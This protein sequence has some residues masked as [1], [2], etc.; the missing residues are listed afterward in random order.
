MPALSSMRRSRWSRLRHQ[1]FAPT[2]GRKLDLR[3][4]FCLATSLRAA[5]GGALVLAAGYDVSLGISDE[6]AQQ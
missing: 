1:A 3:T 2:G 5:V 6:A 4:L